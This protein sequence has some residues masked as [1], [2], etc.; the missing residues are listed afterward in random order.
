MPLAA[1]P[2]PIRHSPPTGYATE[3]VLDT[4]LFKSG[5]RDAEFYRSFW[6]TIRPAGPG[7]E[8]LSMFAPMEHAIVNQTVTPLLDAHDQICNYVSFLKTSPTA[9]PMKRESSIGPFAGQAC[10]RP[11]GQALAMARRGGKMGAC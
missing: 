1:S 4:R 11:L 2:G 8:R 9:R 6:Q 3:D 10:F 7:A 5:A